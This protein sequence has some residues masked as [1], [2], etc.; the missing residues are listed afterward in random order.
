MT[1]VVV[2]G[3]GGGA[4]SHEASRLKATTTAIGRT[5][6]WG[7]SALARCRLASG[8]NF[9]STKSRLAGDSQMDRWLEGRMND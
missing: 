9:V 6:V 2:G 1:T 7:R 3:G 4:A 5:G 8:R